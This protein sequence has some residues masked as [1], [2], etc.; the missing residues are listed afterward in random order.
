MTGPGRP[1]PRRAP[2][3]A[4]RSRAGLQDRRWV[5]FEM[6]VPDKQGL[7]DLAAHLDATGEPHGPVVPTPIGWLLPGLLD[8]DGHESAS[9]TPFPARDPF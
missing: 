1:T 4:S 7:D 8:P 9:T 5:Y 2:D 3:A 6:G